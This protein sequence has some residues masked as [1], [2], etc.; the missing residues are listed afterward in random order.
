M[1]ARYNKQGFRGRWLEDMIDNTNKMYAHRN[2][3]LI[4]KVPTPTQV[5][6]S[7]GK[8]VGAR[9]EKKSTVDFNGILDDGRYIAFDTKECQKPAF[10][11]SAVL[12]HQVE[13]LKKVK[14]MNGEA[15][16][17]IFSER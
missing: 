11:F 17:L 7:N 5:V 6:R 8:I 2:I 10:S 1:V 14:E 13:Y 15:F 3:A 9:Y 16:I 12:S 4:T